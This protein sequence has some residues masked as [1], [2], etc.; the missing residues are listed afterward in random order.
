MVTPDPLPGHT[1]QRFPCDA[2]ERF[3]KPPSETEMRAL[4]AE[5]SMAPLFT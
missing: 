3:S 5:R 4:A 1:T 2:A